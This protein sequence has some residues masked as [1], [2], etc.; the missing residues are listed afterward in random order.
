MPLSRHL[1]CQVLLDA[2]RVD[3][4]LQS[5]LQ[6][7]PHGT[8]QSQHPARQGPGQCPV[9]HSSVDTGATGLPPG[10]HGVHRQGQ[11]W[12]KR[13]Q[14][15]WGRALGYL[16]GVTAPRAQPLAAAPTQLGCGTLSWG[17]FLLSGTQEA[18]IVGI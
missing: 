2:P 11:W 17:G 1:R 9:D 5:A 16:L 10:V 12:P 15:P 14:S 7:D 4:G 18:N 13:E 8:L 3:Q 6:S